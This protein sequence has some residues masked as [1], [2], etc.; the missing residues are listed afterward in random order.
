MTDAAGKTYPEVRLEYSTEYDTDGRIL[1][2]RGSN[3]DGS[4]WVTQYGYDASG[5]LVKTVSGVEGKVLTETSYSYESPRQA[6]E[7]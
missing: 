6:P 1:V 4:Q 5:R 2:T 3:S 7:H